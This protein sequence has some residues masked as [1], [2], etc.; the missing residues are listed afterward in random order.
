MVRRALRHPSRRRRTKAGLSPVRWILVGV[1]SV[2]GLSVTML[3]LRRGR[4]DSSTEVL[5]NLSL[6]SALGAESGASSRSS[7][8]S[9]PSQRRIFPVSCSEFLARR[10]AQGATTTTTTTTT[11]TG[12]SYYDPNQGMVESPKKFIDQLPS[13]PPFWI[14]LHK[15]WFDPMRWN[16]IM[17]RGEYY[18][19]GLTRVFGTILHN[20]PRGRVIDI[21]MNIGWFTL[22]SRS[23]GHDVTAF[24]PN[25]IMHT[26]VCESL[27]VNREQNG[28]GDDGDAVVQSFACGLGATEGMLNLTLGKNPGGSSFHE[29]R[30]QKRNR[31]YMSVPVVR[32]DTI[33][34]QEGWLGDDSSQQR[35]IHLIKID[36][37]GFE[38]PVVAGASR[39]L[40]SGTIR[41]II[42]ESSTTDLRTVV[43]LMA[44]I[45]HAGFQIRQILSVN[46][47]PY[48][49][50]MVGEL[51][52]ALTESSVGMD[53][54]QVH[55]AVR[56]LSTHTLNLWW[57]KM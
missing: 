52:T 8:S 32:L 23:Y 29:E 11:T 42:L 51:N 33:A 4:M 31:K 15:E 48:R 1:A 39:L 46:G 6:L 5:E 28:W 27:Q 56:F 47:D 2:A 14:S 17:N 16:S 45:R 3:L 20:Q 25:P 43:D 53:L 24:D 36:V 19:T 41:N 34:E 57:S 13:T 26:R 22:L 7:S 9:S 54:A 10:R 30:L 12:D 21:G 38:A 18:E 55:T 37:E 35:P 40:H 49:P 44:T 50:E